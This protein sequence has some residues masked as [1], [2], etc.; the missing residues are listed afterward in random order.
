MSALHNRVSNKELKSAILDEVEPRITLSFYKYF[1]IHDPKTFRDNLYIQF[2]RLNILGRIYVAKEGINAQISVLKSNFSTFKSML[3]S[4]YPALNQVR[5]NLAIEDHGK[6]FWVLRLKVRE[7]IVADGIDDDSFN[8][9]DVGEYLRAE[10]VNQMIDDPNTLLVDM[11]NYYEYEVGHFKKAIKVHS[12]TFREQL[13]IAAEMLQG[14][15]GKN[16][17]L[18]CTGGIRCEKA[19]AYLRHKGFR[20]VYHLEGGIIEY[21]RQAK[22]QGLP[23][24]FIGKNF[25]FDER[26]TEQI[27]DDVIA[28]C[29]QCGISCDTH[30]NCKNE[31]CHLLFI[32]CPSCATRFERCCS[33]ACY[34]KKR[35]G[36]PLKSK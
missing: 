10:R 19:S 26:M 2:K 15:K 16:I 11:R 14:K 13:P 4:L 7:R 29:H 28:H 5:L 34:E 18:Y 3:F 24:K 9:E 25:V 32:Q 12:S 33:F 20:N 31:K 8:P 21:V 27:T 36:A 23:I 6:S 30:T 17:I 35:R 22:E 1:N